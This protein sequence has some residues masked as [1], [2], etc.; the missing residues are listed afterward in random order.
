MTDYKEMLVPIKCL[1]GFLFGS[2]QRTSCR[3]VKQIKTKLKALSP[4]TDTCPM[5]MDPNPLTVRLCARRH[6]CWLICG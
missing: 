3:T 4:P 5:R 2:K 1:E 6:L